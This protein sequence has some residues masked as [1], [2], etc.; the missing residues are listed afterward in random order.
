LLESQV[1]IKYSIYTFLDVNPLAA[2]NLACSG[3]VSGFF[4]DREEGYWLE[5]FTENGR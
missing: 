3:R 5:A 4:S 2:Y 1:G